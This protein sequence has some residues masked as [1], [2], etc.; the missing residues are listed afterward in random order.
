MQRPHATG[1]AG[2]LNVVN[3]GTNLPVRVAL[4]DDEVVRDGGLPPDVEG[5]DV[6]SLLVG[7]GRRDAAR[8]LRGRHPLALCTGAPARY[9]P[10]LWMMSATAA[11][12][13]ALMSSPAA[14]RRRISL[15][16]MSGDSTSRRVTRLSA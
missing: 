3:N 15:P 14:T 7:G 13:M 4:A 11:G 12:T 2:I 16:L 6:A 5:G 9:R 8:E 1:S 10:R